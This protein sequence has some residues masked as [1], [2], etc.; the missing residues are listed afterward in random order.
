MQ[1]GILFQFTLSLGGGPGVVSASTHC[2]SV[3]KREGMDDMFPTSLM[4][5]GST[6][7]PGGALYNTQFHLLPLQDVSQLTRKFQVPPLIFQY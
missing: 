2:N 4:R 6:N 1:S 3:D 7:A 5:P